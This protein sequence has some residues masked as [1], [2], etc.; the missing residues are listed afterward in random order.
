MYIMLLHVLLYHSPASPEEVNSNRLEA[1]D[2][3]HQAGAQLAD[4][5]SA[6]LAPLDQYTDVVQYTVAIQ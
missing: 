4:L 3:P 5:R 1:A 2:P 6:L